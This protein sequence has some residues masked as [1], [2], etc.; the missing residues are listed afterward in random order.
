MKT[1]L[2][3]GW[4]N[5][6]TISPRRLFGSLL[7]LSLP[8]STLTTPLS[9]HRDPHC[10]PTSPNPGRQTPGPDSRGPSQNRIKLLTG[11]IQFGTLI[12]YA[13]IAILIHKLILDACNRRNV[14]RPARE[15]LPDRGA[16]G[17][18]R[19]DGAPEH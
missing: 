14:V 16:P 4:R 2:R 13:L 8:S 3:L 11:F 17:G 1:L 9:R 15:R 6:P 5:S 7:S 19:A 12:I 18:P 10:T